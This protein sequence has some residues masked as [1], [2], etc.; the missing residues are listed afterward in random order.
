MF[1]EMQLIDQLTFLRK[2][3]ILYLNYAFMWNEIPPF[4]TKSRKELSLVT[5]D[6]IRIRFV[7]LKLL[8]KDRLKCCGIGKSQAEVNSD[9]KW[10]CQMTKLMAN[11]IQIY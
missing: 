7:N 3:C 11:F 2:L 10:P 5:F 1:D 8:K 6:V 4:Q 9:A